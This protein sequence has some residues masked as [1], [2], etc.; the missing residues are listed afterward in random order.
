VIGGFLRPAEVAARLK[1]SRDTG[2]LCLLYFI[3]KT[4]EVK[5][6]NIIFFSFLYIPFHQNSR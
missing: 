1:R 5:N 3:G 2:L 4:A 6:M